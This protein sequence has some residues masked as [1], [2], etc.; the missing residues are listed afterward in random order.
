MWIPRAGLR[1]CSL[2]QSQTKFK[3]ARNFLEMSNRLWNLN[4]LK[5]R[6]RA[7]FTRGP[8]GQVLVNEIPKVC[9]MERQFQTVDIGIEFWGNSCGSGEWNCND[10]SGRSRQIK[11]L[12]PTLNFCCLQLPSNHAWI[13]ALIIFTVRKP[14]VG[15][16]QSLGLSREIRMVVAESNAEGF[17]SM[18]TCTG[19][20]D[21]GRV[22]NVRHGPVRPWPCAL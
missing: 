1:E 9:Y 10:L 3:S 8:V 5:R 4:G 12:A 2:I 7:Q 19:G 11:S 22:F 13:R 14:I 21:V 18:V 16:S 6:G 15:N 17:W 20:E